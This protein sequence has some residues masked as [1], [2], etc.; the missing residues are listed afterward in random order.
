MGDTQPKQ[1]G[2]ALR[3]GS[4]TGPEAAALRAAKGPGEDRYLTPVGVQYAP[5]SAGQGVGP[6]GRITCPAC[7]AAS[8]GFGAQPQGSRDFGESRSKKNAAAKPLYF[9]ARPAPNNLIQ[10]N[11]VPH[12]SPARLSGG[13]SS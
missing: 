7:L 2:H 10:G 8:G 12:P 9:A 3:R 6:Q 5:G 11:K 1:T 13:F 4:S